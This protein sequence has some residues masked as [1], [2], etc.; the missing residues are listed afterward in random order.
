M[1]LDISLWFC[2]HFKLNFFQ[3]NF[4][5]IWLW[6]LYIGSRGCFLDKSPN[7]FIAEAPSHPLLNLPFKFILPD[8]NCF[9]SFQRDLHWIS[10]SGKIV[11]LETFCE[12]GKVTK[13]VL[14][15]RTMILL[16]SLSLQWLQLYHSLHLAPSDKAFLFP[17]VKN[18]HLVWKQYW[19]DDEVTSAVRTFSR[20]RMRASIPRESMGYNTKG[21]GVKPE[22]KS[23]LTP[24][25]PKKNKHRFSQC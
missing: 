24:P 22:G 8:T 10:N 15:T 25:P 13:G 23:M 1:L 9:V 12:Y 11:V 20:I 17:N 18:T 6:L 7:Y 2:S 4:I 5:F 14:F 21:K 16:T 3:T 19:T